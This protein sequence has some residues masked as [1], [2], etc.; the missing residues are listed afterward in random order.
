[1]RAAETLLWFEMGCLIYKIRLTLMVKWDM[2]HIMSN[3]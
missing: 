2:I 3:V 1:M